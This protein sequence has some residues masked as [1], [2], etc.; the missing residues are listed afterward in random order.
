MFISGLIRIQ[1]SD[2]RAQSFPACCPTYK[3]A[4]QVRG[5]FLS[6][7]IFKSSF[8]FFT[9]LSSRDRSLKQILNRDTVKLREV[10]NQMGLTNIYRTFQPKTKEFTF[11][12]K[13]HGTFSKIDHI[14]G[15]KTTLNR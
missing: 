4:E 15:H 2:L 11:F 8:S 3:R 1:R 7:R 12:S 14:I 13:P 10:I 5:L 9:P 6:C